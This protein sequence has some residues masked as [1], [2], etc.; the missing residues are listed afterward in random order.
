MAPPLPGM[1][2]ETRQSKLAAARKKLREYQLKHGLLPTGPKKK[3]KVK[4][5]NNPETPTS[6]ECH[7]AEDAPKDCAAP[8][9]PPADDTM[10]PGG[11]TSPCAGPSRVTSM[12]STQN[13]DAENGPSP[14]DG[15]KFS[16][17]E[18]LRQLSQQ[19]NGLVSES[20]S[21]INGEGLASSANIKALEKQQNQETVDQLEKE[22]AE[23]EQ[24]RLKE[25]GALR[26]Q[27]QVHI[28]TIGILVSEKTELQTA[29]SHTH[30]AVRHKAGEVED[31]ICR[32]KSS[33]QRI[34]ELERTLSA[35]STQQKQ[36][37]RYTKELTKD[38]DTLRLELY[39]SNKANE[40]LKQQNS[41]LEEKLRV[42]AT[43]N[44][45]MQ[46][47]FEESQK[48]LE[49]SELLLQQLSSQ[50][51]TPDSK[52]QLEQALEE[53]AK[54]EAHVEQLKDL[55]KQLQ[56]ERDQYAEN[57]KEENAIWQQR[58]EQMSEKMCKLREEKEQSVSQVQELETRL[59]ELRNQ[60]A[61]PPP[62]QPPAGPSEMEQRLEAEAK[63]LQKELESLAGQLQAQVQDNEGLSRLNR[64]QEQRLLELEQA[65]ERWGEQAEERKRVLETMQSDR[66][67]IS[68]ALSQN[69]ELKEQLAEL[70][71]GF[72]RLTNEN[73]EITSAFQSEQHVKKEL[74]KKLDQ[75]QEKLEELKET[76]ELKSQE[77]Q[78]LQQQRDQY[79]S[80]LQQ[81]VVSY[82]QHVAAYQQLA[83]EKEVLHK[84]VLLQTQLMDQLQH[85]EVQ[86]KMEA[87]MARQELQE[88]QERLEAANQQNHNLQ[89]QL[90]LMALPGEGDGVDIEEEDKEAPR[91]KLSMPEDLES[92]EAMVAFFNS[93]LAS[94]DEEQARLRGQLKE[95]KLHCRR[96][97]QLAAPSQ[98]PLE[99]EA[100]APRTGG[101]GVP[102]ERHQ[103]LQVAMDKLQGRFTELMQEKVDL[104]D[105]VEELEHRCIQLSGETD[106]IG[107][108]IALYQSQ[109]AVLK[110]RHREKEEY[111]SRLAQ[112]K[113]EMKV[114]L[115]ELQELVL[116]LVGERN[117]WYGKFL[118]AAQNPAGEPSAVAPAPQENVA[119][120]SQ[121]DLH[122]VSLADNVEPTQG[123]ALPGLAAPA[124]NPTAQQIMQ[125]LR[126]IQNP[127]ERPGLGS[128]PCI[129]FFYR[130]DDNDEVKI[131]VI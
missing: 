88:T 49:M 87:D 100:P 56:M 2:E 102:A 128:N 107:E 113:E 60:I 62:Q 124:E 1:S 37:D 65:A 22:K 125:L 84:Q 129:P 120:D 78:S 51:E 4:N 16:S 98:H 15:S 77:A 26:E 12:A 46:I 10:S 90:S 76:V 52:Q 126:E 70:Q 61:V 95:Q 20:T 97:A 104:K 27:L 63:Q 73:M 69:R 116:R 45:A 92:P 48:K 89:A 19:L 121:G 35:I 108:Y 25:Q 39:R 24:K 111:I 96:L 17:T 64:E 112:D 71:N 114:K 54:L 36:A 53:R 72:V 115:L 8:A 3:R 6:H 109:R 94:A 75:L 86:V 91:P 11:V 42:L 67:T 93:A 79:L 50:S 34:A 30:Q 99:G 122:E 44:S 7:S 105:R 81:Y 21:Y 101:N 82:Q 123:E 33:R 43:E 66:T 13:H 58:M 40:D 110:E 59:T 119:A 103:A 38:R 5:G 18:S 29:L 85:E 127:Q 83:S 118:A 117:E 55:L 9:A 57:L 31:L 130:A 32:L 68:R 106:T 131:M 14:M 74:A 80:H 28:Q 23:C 47:R 41:E